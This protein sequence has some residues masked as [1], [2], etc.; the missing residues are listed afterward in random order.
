MRGRPW[1]LLFQLEY[2]RSA[3]DALE[4]KSAIRDRRLDRLNEAE[5]ADDTVATWIGLHG[6][7]CGQTH[8]AL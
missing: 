4:W 8:D 1:T 6:R 3:D 7:L 2:L 5:A